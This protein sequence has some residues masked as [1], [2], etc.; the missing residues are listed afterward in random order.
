MNRVKILIY[1]LY[2]KIR[3]KF[4]LAHIQFAL[5]CIVIVSKLQLYINRQE[6]GIIIRLVESKIFWKTH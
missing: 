6:N 5:N 1:Q 3:T 4:K 2:A